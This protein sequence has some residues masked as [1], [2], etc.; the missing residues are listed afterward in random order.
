MFRSFFITKY[1]FSQRTICRCLLSPKVVRFNSV[2][3]YF[4]KIFITKSFSN[5]NVQIF[6]IHKKFP[7]FKY[8]PFRTWR[9]NK[10]LL[11]VQ[12]LCQSLS[13]TFLGHGPCQEKK[14][15]TQSPYLIFRFSHF[16]NCSQNG[17]CEIWRETLNYYHF[18][19]RF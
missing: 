19:F 4:L 10:F 11:T 5:S 3:T 15:L 13:V 14:P 12:Q 1:F 7:Y 17:N 6:Y 18:T 8:F 2:F 9:K 16:L